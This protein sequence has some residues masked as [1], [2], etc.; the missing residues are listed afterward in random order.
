MTRLLD[1]LNPEQ[2]RAV[3]TTD[4]P[5]LVLAGAGTGKTKVVTTR[6][7]RLL[8]KG[9]APES[10]L[11]MTFTNKAAGEMRER[12]ARAAGAEAARRVTVGTFHAFCVRILRVHGEAIGIRDGLRV[13][14]D[15]AEAIGVGR[16]RDRKR[17]GLDE[18]RPG[19]DGVD[20]RHAPGLHT[21]MAGI[22]RC[23]GPG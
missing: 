18:Q 8:E 12:V 4:G 3:E 5:L 16:W 20:H 9:A 17:R 21:K 14:D 11:A 6:I 15:L 1:G 2:R 22:L 19:E 7:A 13:D 23:S 10:V